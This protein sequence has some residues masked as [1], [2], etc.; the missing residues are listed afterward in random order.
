MD[1]ALF[2]TSA[3]A[4]GCG[5][6]TVLTGETEVVVFERQ[7]ARKVNRVDDV[8]LS[9]QSELPTHYTPQTTL[10]RMRFAAAPSF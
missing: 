5:S 10:A 6:S 1:I 3:P 7:K 8:I 9:E 4:A 2:E